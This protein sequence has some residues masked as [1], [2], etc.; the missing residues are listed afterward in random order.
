MRIKVVKN[1]VNKTGFTLIE[2]LIVV[3]IIGLLASI[4]LPGYRKAVEKSKASEAL[5]NLSALSKSEH[6]FYLA[7]NKYTQDFSDLDIQLQ[8]T[9]DDEDEVLKT[10]Y[11]DYKL[12]STGILASRNNKEYSIYRD[13]ETNQIMCTPGTHY[14]C[15]DLGAFT[16]TACENAN[17]AW[18][19]TNSTCYATNEARCNGLYPND[20]LWH[21]DSENHE[22]DYCGYKGVRTLKKTFSEGMECIS[23]YSYTH[24]E[25][26]TIEYGAK[27]ISYGYEGCARATIN[28]GGICE[29]HG[30]N[31]CIISNVNAGGECHAKASGA[32]RESTYI[33][34]GCCRGTYCPSDSPK[35]DC[36]IDEETGMHKT[37]C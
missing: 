32:C 28:S 31:G 5:S 34:T 13:Y 24:C 1:A 4:A 7:K 36:P 8:G 14:I 29:G 9:M 18:A 11:F 19:N 20:N 22:N 35:C 26:P 21:E 30:Y 23:V 2:I 25:S 12:L 15:D 37:S 3:L 16:K 6:S 10:E 27:C 17:M 33:G